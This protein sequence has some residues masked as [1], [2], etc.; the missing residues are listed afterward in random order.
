MESAVVMKVGAPL[1]VFGTY[2]AGEAVLMESAVVIKA[3]A[4]PCVLGTYGAGEA[5]SP[6]GAVVKGWAPPS[7]LLTYGAGKALF[8]VAEVKIRA[9]LS[10]L[11]GRTGR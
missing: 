10:L 5:L 1:S 11:W 8:G 2:G 9:P 4:P 3:G 7:L 6:G